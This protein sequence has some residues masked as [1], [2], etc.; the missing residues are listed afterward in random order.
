LVE[1]FN[2]VE[3]TEPELLKENPDKVNMLQLHRPFD[4]D[5]AIKLD[6]DATKET[7]TKFVSTH[8]YPYLDG[9]QQAWPRLN[10]RADHIFLVFADTTDEEEWTPIS[11]FLTKLAKANLDKVGFAYLGKD[12]F[13]R[14]PQFG[15]SGQVFPSAII[16]NPKA[17]KTHLWDEKQTFDEES[18]T[19]FVNGVLDGSI[20]PHFKTQDAPETNDEDVLVV[21]GSTFDEL[22]IDNDKDVLVE[23]YAP[24]CGHCK[25]LAPIYDELGE[26]YEENDDVIIAK[27]DASANDNNHIKVRSFPTIFLFPAGAKSEPI[28]FNGDRT[29]EGFVAF[30]EEN[31]THLKGDSAESEHGHGHDHD[32]EDL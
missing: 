31:A 6:Q 15:L 20:K 13:G 3:V 7:V 16:M 11:E 1:G 5:L 23:F 2:F 14:V 21:V 27:I 9:A 12:F 8:G 30:L 32:H 19:A 18:V 25:Q 28:E 22:V 26:H 29:V 4:E 17:E 10:A 24:W